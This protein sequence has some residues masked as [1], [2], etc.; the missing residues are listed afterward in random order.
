MP[1]GPRLPGTKNSCPVQH[2]DRFN[3]NRYVKIYILTI[4]S[5][6]NSGGGRM[7]ADDISEYDVDVLDDAR[8]LDKTLSSL[9]G[10][11]W[12]VN[13]PRARLGVVK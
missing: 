10:G 11:Q 7:H 4:N 5:S 8:C 13:G 1:D 2:H 9:G 3:I 6:Q 12:L